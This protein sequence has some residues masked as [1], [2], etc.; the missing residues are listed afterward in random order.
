[1]IVN[2][3]QDP[4]RANELVITEKAGEDTIGVSFVVKD[5]D[6]SVLQ[7]MIEEGRKALAHKIIKHMESKGKTIN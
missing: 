7:K 2:I 5:M 1:M 6:V 3:T 4:V